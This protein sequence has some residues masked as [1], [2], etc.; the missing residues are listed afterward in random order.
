[1]CSTFAVPPSRARSPARSLAIG[2]RL[3][4]RSRSAWPASAAP[5][6]GS[7]GPAP[8]AP[9]VRPN[10]VASPIRGRC[11]DDVPDARAG[12]VGDTNRHHV[13]FAIALRTRPRS[14][15]ETAPRSVLEPDLGGS[16]RGPRLIVTR[17]DQLD[18]EA[19]ERSKIVQ[20]L[21]ASRRHPR[22]IKRLARNRVD[23][24]HSL[25]DPSLRA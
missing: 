3:P 19:V 4:S 12:A 24:A 20:R 17:S 14:L 10:P 2:L 8:A 23:R 25:N 15:Q 5:R 18:L 9:A 1:M 22:P 6:S 21:E 13:R 16:P 11:A 7:P